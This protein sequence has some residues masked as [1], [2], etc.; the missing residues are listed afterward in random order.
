MSVSHCAQQA[1]VVPL[2]DWLPPSL[3]SVW[4]HPESEALVF[5]YCASVF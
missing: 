3:V 1:A 2:D 5:S 4:N